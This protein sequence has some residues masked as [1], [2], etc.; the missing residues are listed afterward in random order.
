[1]KELNI[2]VK[3]HIETIKTYSYSFIDIKGVRVL[4]EG[5]KNYEDLL[6]SVKQKTKSLKSKKSKLNWKIKWFSRKYKGKVVVCRT[7]PIPGRS[8]QNQKS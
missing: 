1:M 3:A 7:F 8:T 6:K 2:E 5:I 4:V